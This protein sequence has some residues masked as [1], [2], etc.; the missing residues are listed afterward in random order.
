MVPWLPSSSSCAHLF[1]AAAAAIVDEHCRQTTSCAGGAATATPWQARWLRRPCR[2]LTA[3]AAAAPT[4]DLET[5]RNSLLREQEQQG[6]HGLRRT[7]WAHWRQ[8][9]PGLNPAHRSHRS[10][11]QRE[12]MNRDA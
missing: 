7:L 6:Q 9:H 10:K 12:T 1:A 5:V 3:A 11:K 2:Q 8:P 4:F